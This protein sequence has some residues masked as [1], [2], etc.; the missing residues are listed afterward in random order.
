MI[1]PTRETLRVPAPISSL[2][3]TRRAGGEGGLAIVGL[4]GRYHRQEGGVL[5]PPFGDACRRLSGV[6][7]APTT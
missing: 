3:G 5:L 7:W 6:K 2:C 4:A 1:C